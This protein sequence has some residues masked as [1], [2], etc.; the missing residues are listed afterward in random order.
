MRL[1]R[2]AILRLRLN[3]G[4]RR[5]GERRLH[6]ADEAEAKLGDRADQA[7]AGAVVSDRLAGRLD[8]AGDGGVRDDAAL[9]DLLDDLVL[10][11]QPFAVF[12]E[13][14]EQR[15]DLRLDGDDGA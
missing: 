15:K 3:A 6:L 5:R 8:A 11:D 9:P 2:L 12:D 13:Q 4:V 14:A 10:G 1:Q 7:L